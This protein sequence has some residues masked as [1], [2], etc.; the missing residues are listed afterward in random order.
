MMPVMLPQ[1]NQELI[2]TMSDRT[3]LYGFSI[4]KICQDRYSCKIY[5]V[6]SWKTKTSKE[7]N[8]RK[9]TYICPSCFKR[10]RRLD[11][12]ESDGII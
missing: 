11:K 1:K 8:D 2:W 7:K 10:S 5:S 3:E 12:F 4:C 9:N 6:Y